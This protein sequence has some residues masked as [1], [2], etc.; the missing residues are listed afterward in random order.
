MAQELAE[1]QQ[2]DRVAAARVP[3]MWRN[4]R[5]ENSDPNINRGAF[6]QAKQY[7]EK[8]NPKTSPSLVLFSQNYGTGKTHL[9]ACIANHV[10]HA[11]R[12]SVVYQKARDLLLDIRSTFSDH[13]IETEAGILDRVLSVDLLVLDDVGVDSPSEWLRSTYWTL[14]DRR[15]EWGLPVVVT[16]NYPF[17]AEDDERSLGD[18]IG[19]GVASR[20]RQ[21]CG[22][23]VIHFKGVDLR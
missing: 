21:M 9:A 19:F 5:F 22:G 14:L 11:L 7:A 1:Q 15:L 4:V 13:G 12:Y 20:L 6:I 3:M 18:R 23:N 16:T 8:F 10:L 2:R 17:E